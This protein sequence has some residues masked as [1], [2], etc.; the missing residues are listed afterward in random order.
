MTRMSRDITMCH[1]RLQAKAKELVAECAKVGIKIKITD[2]FRSVA[3]QDALYAKGRTTA[4]KIVTN[5]RGT[6]Y[7]SMHMWGVAFD[8]CLDSR[9]GAYDNSSGLFNKVGAIGKKIGLEWGGDW[10][11]FVDLPH[12]QLPNWGSTTSRL[13][14]EFGRPAVFMQ[15]WKAEEGEDTMEKR[16]NT[17]NELPTWARPTIQKL[18]DEGKFA[19]KNKLDLSM[20]MVRV[21]VV[22]SR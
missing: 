17:I 11:S 16:Y 22:L 19:D 10:T 15:S 20:D 1:P 18:V 4:G 6:D 13:K 8:F 21:L 7:A 9:T 14:K 2:C 12:F 3:E 5:C